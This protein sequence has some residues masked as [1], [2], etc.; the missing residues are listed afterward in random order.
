M[1]DKKTLVVTD[2]TNGLK[3]HEL[4]WNLSTSGMCAIDWESTAGESDMNPA[5]AG[6]RTGTTS[7]LTNLW[8]MRSHKQE[9]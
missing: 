6:T 7:Y 3:R 5:T 9:E 2:L 4:P 1:Q 8:K